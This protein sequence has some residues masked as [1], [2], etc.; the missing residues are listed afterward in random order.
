MGHKPTFY[1][2]FFDGRLYEVKQP[3][4]DVSAV[5]PSLDGASCREQS[6]VHLP[7]DRRQS[8]KTSYLSPASRNNN[9][10]VIILV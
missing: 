8:A 1:L 10:S 9:I 3:L 2:R 6:F 4:K 7:G 5:T